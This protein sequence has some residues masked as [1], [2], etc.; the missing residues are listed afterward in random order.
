MRSFPTAVAM[1]VALCNVTAAFAH[2]DLAARVGASREALKP[3]AGALQ[4]QL[5]SAMAVGGPAAAVEVCKTA[6]PEIAAAASDAQGWHIG[7]TS[8]KLRNPADTPY[9][10][11]LAVLREFEGSGIVTS[12]WAYRSQCKD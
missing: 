4:E 6:A 7:R 11:E 2:E 12:A 3:F 8:L 9:A 10:W 5:M 1:V